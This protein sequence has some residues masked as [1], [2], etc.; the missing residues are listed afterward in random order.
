MAAGFGFSKIFLAN[1]A[2]EAFGGA[3]SQKNDFCTKRKGFYMIAKK[4]LR[5]ISWVLMAVFLLIILFNVTCFIKRTAFGDSCPTVLGVGAAVVIS[6]SMEPNISLYDL[7]II[8]EKDEYHVD[9]VVIFRNNTYCVTHRILAMETDENGQVWVTTKGDA[10][11]APD[12]PIPLED[13]VGKVIITIPKIGYVQ[14]FLQQPLGFLF[15]TLMTG[16]F[17]LLPEWVDRMKKRRDDE[18]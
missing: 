13:I 4:I 14:N 2:S 9:E 18:H 15:L 6:G 16:A 3:I 12:S 7:V 8:H 5:V 1:R 17:L 11:N 10:N